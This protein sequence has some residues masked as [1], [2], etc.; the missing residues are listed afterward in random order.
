[1]NILNII[2]LKRFS[3]NKLKTHT[4]DLRGKEVKSFGNLI[5]IILILLI[6]CKSEDRYYRP[7]LPEK[8][9]SLGII[10]IDDTTHSK[11]YWDSYVNKFFGH[12][13]LFEKSHQSEYP[14]EEYAPLREFSFS[15]YTE[16]DNII[17]YKGAPS[18][19]NFL[20]VDLTD[21]LSFL[22]GEKYYLKASEKDSPEITAEIKATELPPTP[23]LLSIRK[24]KVAYTKPLYGWPL[25][26]IDSL[27]SA[28]IKVSFYAT[29]RNQFYVLLLDS[30]HSEPSMGSTIYES[31]VDFTVSQSN[32]Q[33]FFSEL[34]G[35]K[36]RHMSILPDG[37]EE[38]ETP[39]F[40]YFIDGRQ[41]EGN[42]CD[43]TISTLFHGP[44]SVWQGPWDRDTEDYYSL[45]FKLI[46]I[47]EEV[48][49]FEK[50][51][52]T[53]QRTKSDPFSEPVYLNGNIKGGN[54][55]F[56]ICR[57]KDLVINLSPPY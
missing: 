45:R 56:A 40:A 17:N 21:S 11:R 22:P 26:R 48:Y 6:Q 41:I 16:H 3:M 5:I 30:K 9:C 42:K 35:L 32:T 52:Y 28:V 34:I 4:R 29:N 39:V 1:M 46:S 2:P 10:D 31:Y 53:Y 23:L 51:L 7:N 36:T 55:I 24:E 13:I 27:K 47:P 18:I 12:Y 19:D 14:S 38:V 20:R 43:I 25:D 44:Y 54:G 49:L 50:S 57:S 37:M 8:L 15:I 33:G